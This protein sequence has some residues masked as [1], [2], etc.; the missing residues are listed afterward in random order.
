MSAICSIGQGHGDS[1]KKRRGES[2]EFDRQSSDK[3]TCEPMLYNVY[4]LGV[5]QKVLDD[6]FTRKSSF[7]HLVHFI[8]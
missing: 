3:V 4:T 8:L 7:K 1:S 6:P 2:L 5:F